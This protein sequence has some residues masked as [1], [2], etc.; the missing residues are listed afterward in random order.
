MLSDKK[1]I[2]SNSYFKQGRFFMTTC[3]SFQQC[4]GC[5]YQHLPFE[6]YITNK[7]NFVKT[8]FLNQ[9]IDCKIEPIISIPFG[10][11]R[12]ATFAFQKG[13]I[14][15][16]A[17]KSHQI[18]SLNACPALIKPL[19]DF[20]PK[21]QELIKQFKGSGEIA[22]LN[23]PFGIDMHIKRSGVGELT[24]NQREILAEFSLK[25][26]VA[27]LLY[28]KEPIVQQIQ[29]PFPADAF[30]QPSAEGEETLVNLVLTHLGN[31]KKIADLFCGSGTFTK[32]I[33][34]KGISVQGYDIASDS[35]KALGNIGFERD[36]FRNPLL[37]NELELFDTVVIDPPRA[38]AKEQCRQLAQSQIQRIL[39]ISCNPNTASRDI[40]DLINGGYKL[41]KVVPVDQFVYTNHIEIF[42]IL[43][44]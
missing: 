9:G 23:T 30:L 6:E 44:K 11:R 4:G 36:L 2:L 32:P 31:A 3:P 40:K 14:G 39:M 7:Q 5:L 12:R 19:S 27:R 16:N 25:N 15:F 37:P 41:E 21:L 10:T 43:T 1:T 34:Q 26:N 35:L 29:L 38:G 18:I 24:L 8:A 28:N 33:Y 13:K 17:L 42:C 20:L 22:V